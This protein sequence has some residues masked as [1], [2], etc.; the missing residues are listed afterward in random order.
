MR[1]I[2]VILIVCLVYCGIGN[3]AQV[4]F[5]VETD[6]KRVILEAGQTNDTELYSTKADKTNVL[7]KDNTTPFTPDADYEPATK[8]YVDDNAGGG[9]NVSTSGTPVANDIP[10]F[11]DGT[12]IE[13]RSYTELKT[14][15]SLE[16]VDNTSDANKPIGVATQTALDG[17]ADSTYNLAALSDGDMAG[18]KAAGLNA[19]A[20]IAKYQGV[21]TDPTTGEYLIADRSVANCAERASGMATTTGTDGEPLTILKN[22]YVRNT[23]WSWTVGGQLYFDNSGNLTQTATTTENE[24]YQPV[25]IA[26][27]AD[28]VEININDI[29]GFGLVDNP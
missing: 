14:D 19:G 7:E 15:L 8:K 22:G 29:T 11:V 1:K 17:K 3:A 28:I 20:T 25:G 4:T 16:N 12:S 26:R 9:G 21:Y 10:R 18:E 13:G 27:T 5:N 2:F 6:T 23:A 24:C